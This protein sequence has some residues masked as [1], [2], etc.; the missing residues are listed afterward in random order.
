[1]NLNKFL[2]KNILLLTGLIIVIQNNAFAGLETPTGYNVNLQK[3]EFH[4]VGTPSTEYFT[5]RSGSSDVNIASKLPNEPCA[6]LGPSATPPKGT[7]DQ[8]RVTVST[9]MTLTGRTTGNLSNGLPCRTVANGTAVSNPFGD[10]SVSVAYLGSTDGGT[11]QPEAVTVPSGTSVVFPTGFSL[12]GN[13]IQ[14]TVPVNFTVANSVPQGTVSF[15]V[16]NGIDFEVNPS[17]V[18]QCFVFPAAP[19]ISISVA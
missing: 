8:F 16:A 13:T 14:G 15:N 11:P 18:A 7:Y 5:Y 1:M 2:Q 6:T 10:G 4:K 19:S 12:V 3:V 17:N 9:S